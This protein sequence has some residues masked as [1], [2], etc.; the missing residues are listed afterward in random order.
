MT[1]FDDLEQPR[2]DLGKSIHR[3]LGK[4]KMSFLQIP[5]GQTAINVPETTS[6][7][8]T[9]G[10][11]QRMVAETKEELAST[12]AIVHA[13]TLHL[14]DEQQAA[15]KETAEKYMAA[16]TSA[17]TQECEELEKAEKAEKSNIVLPKGNPRF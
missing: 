12:S 17:I 1:L 8:Q 15:I 16:Q 7:L 4:I 3:L 11:L 5:V 10:M 2:V 6:L 9:L 13:M 14:P